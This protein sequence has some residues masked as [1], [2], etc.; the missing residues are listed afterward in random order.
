M[1]NVNRRQYL[2]SLFADALAAVDELR[3]EP[4][5]RLDEIASLPD[6]VLRAM[7][8]VPFPGAALSVEEGWL[9]LRKNPAESLK[10]HLPLSAPQIYALG[11][12]DGQH[13]IAEICAETEAAFEL[14]PSMAGELVKTLFVTL[15]ESGVCQ[16]LD[17]PE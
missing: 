5:F 12:F 4:H 1:K 10:R 17:R 7:V 3:G 13:S 9:L 6:S 16:P 8:P 14:S 15:A 2:H 11:R